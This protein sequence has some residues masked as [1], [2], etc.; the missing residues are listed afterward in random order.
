MIR[1]EFT[2]SEARKKTRNQFSRKKGPRNSVLSRNYLK[3]HGQMKWKEKLREKAYSLTKVYIYFAF[4]H[5]AICARCKFSRVAPLFI[6]GRGGGET[7][8]LIASWGRSQIW[9]ATCRKEN[10]EKNYPFP[11]LLQMST[12]RSHADWRFQFLC[13]GGKYFSGKKSGCSFLCQDNSA[14]NK[15]TSLTQTLL[16]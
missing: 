13:Q 11:H 10:L 16:L 7:E 8:Q 5:V 3:A 12:Q 9:S 15:M 2:W 6:Q 14:I 4:S 1:I